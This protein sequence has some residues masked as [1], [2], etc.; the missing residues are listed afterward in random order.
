MLLT[1]PKIKTLNVSSFGGSY[2]FIY[3]SMS[4]G[5]AYQ[6]IDKYYALSFKP[7]WGGNC[8]TLW[9]IITIMMLILT[10]VK[11]KAWRQTFHSC[12]RAFKIA[13]DMTGVQTVHPEHRK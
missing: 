4:I 12:Q 10:R 1:K 13:T 8:P 3:C 7:Q 11:W 2:K 6:I 5:S 9:G